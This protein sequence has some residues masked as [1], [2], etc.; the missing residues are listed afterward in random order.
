MSIASY[1]PRRAATS[2]ILI[3]A[4]LDVVAL[5]IVLPVLPRLIE[6]MSS[7]PADAAWLNGAFV[8]LWA[9][10]QFAASPLLGVLSDRFG[11]RPVI[12]ISTIGLALDYVLMAL[13]PNLAW[14]VV[15]RLLGGLTSANIGTVYAYMADI[16]PEEKRAKAFGLVGAAVSAGFV[17]GPVLGGLASEWGLRAPFWIAAAL[18]ALAFVYGLFVLP[19]SLPTDRRTPFAW[20]RANPIGSIALLR[21]HVDLPRLASVNF[22]MQFCHYVFHAVFVLYAAA[23]YGFSTFEVGVLLAFTALLDIGVQTALVGRF[24]ARFGEAMTL[25]V[26]LV[27]GAVG[28]AA[29]GLAPTPASFIAALIPMSMWGLSLPTLQSL[30][31]ARV[32]DSQQGELQGANASVV[33]VA[34]ISAPLVFGG[35]YAWSSG[36]AVS[37]SGAP[38]LLAAVLLAVCAVVVTTGAVRTD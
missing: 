6:S 32:S 5:G 14:L 31:T 1:G 34:G 16:T 21:S 30:M 27:M 37:I 10:M 9:A 20:R 11:R 12:L 24:V 7:S 19:E 25:R 4:A 18:S 13:A 38:F 17:L 36:V 35:V 23:R 29:M 33:A 28:I 8:A 2:F 26:G 3:T 15:G 22:L